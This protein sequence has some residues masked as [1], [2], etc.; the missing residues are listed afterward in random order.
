MVAVSSGGQEERA[1][2]GFSGLKDGVT[3]DA[4]QRREKYG[5]E[6]KLEGNMISSHVE[7]VH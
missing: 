2:P 3:G 1:S 4:I 7:T 6:R 5:G